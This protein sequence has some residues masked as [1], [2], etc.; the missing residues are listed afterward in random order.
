MELH[1]VKTDMCFWKLLIHVHVVRRY[2]KKFFPGKTPTSQMAYKCHNAAVVASFLLAGVWS[3]KTTHAARGSGA[4]NASDM[5]CV[6]GPE[7]WWILCWL[8]P[9]LICILDTPSNLLAGAHM[10]KL[11]SLVTGT[12][13]TWF[14]HMSTVFRSLR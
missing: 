7:F 12:Q 5:G 11:L 4:R 6:S 2:D 9:E 1:L 13:T 3:K 14:A 10:Q 8:R